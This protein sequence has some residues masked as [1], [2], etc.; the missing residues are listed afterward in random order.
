[1]AVKRRESLSF[2]LIKGVMIVF[3]GGHSYVH[4]SQKSNPEAFA[5]LPADH[6]NLAMQRS[7]NIAKHD[8]QEAKDQASKAHH[9]RAAAEKDLEATQS[10]AHSDSK[11]AT[12]KIKTLEVH[13]THQRLFGFQF[14][15]QS[16]MN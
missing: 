9:K 14:S 1:M 12:S 3:A 2:N 8:Y 7:L 16:S 11:Q 10:K 13:Y 5:I 4:S 15:S 6:L